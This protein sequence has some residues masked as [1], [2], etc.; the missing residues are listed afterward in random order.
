MVVRRGYK[1]CGCQIS[2]K[3]TLLMGVIFRVGKI[4]PRTH[5]ITCGVDIPE[6]AAQPDDGRWE[7][8]TFGRLKRLDPDALRDDVPADERLKERA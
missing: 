3:G 4:W 1:Y 6:N 7:V 5:C 2:Q 8:S